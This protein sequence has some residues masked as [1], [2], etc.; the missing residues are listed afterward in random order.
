[1]SKSRIKISIFGKVQGVGFRAS[2]L[3]YA[4]KNGITGWTSN[5]SDGNLV[6]NAEGEKNQIID[7]I[8]WCKVGPKNAVIERSEAYYQKYKNEFSRFEIRK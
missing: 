3:K 8:E 2:I 4:K 7:F 1:M 6:I 5:T